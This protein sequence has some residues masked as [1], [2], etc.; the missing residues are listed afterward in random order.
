MR[1]QSTKAIGSRQCKT[2][3]PKSVHHHQPPSQ[4]VET[5]C[6]NV[7]SKAP[8]RTVR[9]CRREQKCRNTWRGMANHP[10]RECRSGRGPHNRP[11]VAPEASASGDRA[12]RAEAAAAAGGTEGG[13]AVDSHAR[14]APRRNRGGGGRVGS[15]NRGGEAAAAGGAGARP[16]PGAGNTSKET[17]RRRCR[18]G[19]QGGALEFR[20]GAYEGR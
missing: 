15:S 13:G 6:R 4:L 10:K 11:R 7:R 8:R 1:D 3:P 5:R 19:R 9:T 20:R 12:R 16:H 18:L 14:K 17:A 2:I